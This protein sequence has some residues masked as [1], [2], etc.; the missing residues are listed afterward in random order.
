MGKVIGY[1]VVR[2]KGSRLLGSEMLVSA[3]SKTYELEYKVGTR[4]VPKLDGSKLFAFLTEE[5]AITF[6]DKNCAADST[7]IVYQAELENVEPME[8]LVLKLREGKVK[9]VQL[10]WKWYQGKANNKESLSLLKGGDY[11]QKPPVGTILCDSVTLLKRI[12]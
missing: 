7:D 3:C 4:V 6:I 8:I 10:Y 12:V 5:D 9:Y 2:V 1:K 11:M